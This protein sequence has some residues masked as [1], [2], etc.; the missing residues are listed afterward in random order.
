VDDWPR[1]A[2]EIGATF[3][4]DRGS[5]PAIRRRTGGWTLSLQM[6]TVSPQGVND[7]EKQKVA[8]ILTVP[9]IN[10]G[11]LDLSICREGIAERMFK[12]FGPQDV[13]TG[14]AE[15]DRRFMCRA[16]DEERCR[17]VLA[18]PSIRS[19]ILAAP[20][21]FLTLS[22]YR[23]NA[24]DRFLAGLVR[25]F[26]PHLV[27]GMEAATKDRLECCHV[28]VLSGADAIKRVFDLCEAMLARLEQLDFARP[29]AGT[30]LH[31]D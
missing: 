28:G 26:L 7:P 8:T 30:K 2:A 21:H 10:S 11:A 12:V 6:G 14:D 20:E 18:D 17:Q 27:A 5:P 25:K 16:N 13:E 29:A 9:I 22:W 31:F 19:L 3:E 4:H 15:F 24:V 1:I 23:P